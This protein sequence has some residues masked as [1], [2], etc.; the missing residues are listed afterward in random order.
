MNKLFYSIYRLYSL[1]AHIEYLKGHN[2]KKKMGM[3]NQQMQCEENNWY[4]VSD[5]RF[6]SMCVYVCVCVVATAYL[7]CVYTLYIYTYL[8]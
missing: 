7:E 5:E 4:D 1:Q 6:V 3:K 8:R 2:Q